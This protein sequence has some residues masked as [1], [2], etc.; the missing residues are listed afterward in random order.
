LG[1][2]HP[3]ELALL[4]ERTQTLTDRACERI[5]TRRTLENPSNTLLTGVSK[6]TMDEIRGVVASLD[7]EVEA[8]IAARQ[9]AAIAAGQRALMLIPSGGAIAV[10]LLVLAIAALARMSRLRRLADAALWRESSMLRSVLSSMREG[11][12]VADA[13]GRLLHFNES[14]ERILGVGAR[15]VPIEQWSAV[16]GA[17]D[18][19]GTTP[20]PSAELPLARAL[21]GESVDDAELV[22]RN[23]NLSGPVRI[24]LN[25]RPLKHS[26]TELRGGVVVFRDIT[27]IR[28]VEEHLGKIG[29]DLQDALSLNPA[30]N[31]PATAAAPGASQ[32]SEP[33]EAS[34]PGSAAHE[35]SGLESL[36]Q[37]LELASSQLT[38][39]HQEL[40]QKVAE[41]DEF[42][43]VASHDLQEPLRKLISFGALLE[44]DAGENLPPQAARDLKFISDAA[45]RMQ[46]LVQD[47][48]SLSRAGRAALESH[49]V[50]LARC[51]QSAISALSTRIEETH[52]RVTIDELPTL[53]GD[54]VMLTQLYQNLIGNALK[55][56]RGR[57]PQIHLSAD[58]DGW[59]WK[60][61]VHDN[62]IG[63]EPR[64]CEQIFGPFKRLHGRDEYEGT[65]IGLAICRKA[66]DRHGGRIWVESQIEKG[67][68]FYFT[69]PIAEDA[70]CLETK[71]VL[72]S[73]C[74]PK[75]ILVTR[76]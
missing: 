73:S 20:M 66:A 37:S 35:T 18:G 28:R 2:R 8:L 51:A 62:G 46:R 39:A 42:T 21:R 16:Y 69:L 32:P 5:E 30:Q 6:A 13:Q 27:Q 26:D 11:V 7:S 53:Y 12:V 34:G 41:L 63:I 54:P 58:R 44:R 15:D 72:P 48:L 61:G 75:T 50:S 52:A 60:L 33:V 25:S 56:V 76:N 23:E 49:Q 64:F 40:A 19:D 17:F 1:K 10:L 29:R 59:F 68:S 67:S 24:S 38:L 14:A 47:L 74:L 65:G 9:G 71:T 55:F 45:A 3:R 4:D 70:K 57:E 36:T 22:I 43:Y 31:G